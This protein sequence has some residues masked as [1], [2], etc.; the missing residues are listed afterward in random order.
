[1]WQDLR[2]IVSS[3][4]NFIVSASRTAEKSVLLVENEMDNL[5]ELQNLRFDEI[6]KERQAL[7]TDA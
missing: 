4:T 7:L 5:T 6:R 2:T 1:M 3:I